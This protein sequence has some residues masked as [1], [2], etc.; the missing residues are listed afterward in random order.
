MSDQSILH[1]SA[2]AV[3]G[4]G[5]MILGPSGSG[6]SRITSDAIMLGAKLIADDRVLLQ[7]MMGMISVLPVPELANVMEL[8]GLG[9]IR[10]N[11]T[12]A[13][14][15]LHLVIE[16]DPACDERMP[17]QEKRSFLGVELPYIRV[18]AVP[19]ISAGNVL[20]YLKAMQE[21][22]VLPADWKPNAA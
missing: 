22:R 11:D 4:A 21:G 7:P 5:C 19:K 12:L 9:L 17:V 16:L 14:H 15:V 2:F 1:A 3:H 6:K 10:F 18:P 13:K 8:R 20:M